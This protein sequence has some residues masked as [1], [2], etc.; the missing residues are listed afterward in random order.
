MPH[1]TARR[2]L[3]WHFPVFQRDVAEGMA[4]YSFPVHPW[5]QAF[6]STEK[7]TP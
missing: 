6:R 3:F 2:H 4:R 7:E 1:V 5:L